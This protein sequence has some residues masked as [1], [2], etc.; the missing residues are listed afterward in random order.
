MQ[1]IIIKSVK[2]IQNPIYLSPKKKYKKKFN[3]EMNQK[4]QS[5]YTN[6]KLKFCHI[7]N[8]K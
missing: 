3:V 2:A 6:F 1:N 7:S 5:R 4:T 8:C